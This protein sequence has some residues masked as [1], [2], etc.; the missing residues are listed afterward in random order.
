MNSGLYSHGT[1]GSND[2]VGTD[3]SNDEVG[4]D[5]SNDQSDIKN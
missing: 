5:G 4:T 2:E 3:G 1:D